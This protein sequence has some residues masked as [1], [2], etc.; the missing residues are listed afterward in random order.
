MKYLTPEIVKEKCVLMRVDFNV[1]LDEEGNVIDDFRIQKTL[2]TIK[3]LKEKGAEKIILISHLGQPEK[4]DFWT[5]KFTLKS[6]AVYLEK[7]LKE[8]IH[9]ERS[10]KKGSAEQGETGSYFE[11]SEKKGNPY[12]C[13]LKD[14]KEIK[15]MIDKSEKGAIWLLEN[16]RYHEAEEKND[17][18]FAR[19]LS[20]LGDLYINEAF[21]V[22]HREVASICAITEFLPSYP[23]FLFEE[24][25]KHLDNIITNSES[26]LV[27]ILGGAKVEDKLPLIETFSLKADW[28]LIGGVIANTILKAW[29]FEIGNSLYEEKI[30]GKA[31]NLGSKI[32]ELMLPGDFF[33]LAQ[34]QQKKNRELGQIEKGDNILDIGQVAAYTFGKIIQKAATIF[35]NGPMGKI[36]DKKFEDGTKTIIEAILENKTAKIIIGGGDTLMA[37]KILKPEYKIQNTEYRFF[38]T[39]GGAMLKYLAGK[40]LPGLKALS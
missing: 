3:F 30:I 15:N 16:I 23:G 24:E 7:T 34:N 31:K 38:S 14:F 25:I 39:G 19:E 11:Q 36:E 27:I 6:I 35:W 1:D 26:P 21:S 40:P 33:V 5:E 17:R 10:E 22:S 8:K 37:F 29:N 12:F 13:S 4:K 28:L 9:F 2:P 18:D 32:A 20:Q